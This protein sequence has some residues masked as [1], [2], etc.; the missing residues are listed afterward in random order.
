[1]YL[2]DH[3]VFGVDLNPVAVELAEV[4]LWLNALSDDRFV[5]WFGLQ[6]HCGNSLIGARR[7]TFPSSSLTVASSSDSHSWLNRAPEKLPMNEL[8]PKGQI[9]HF[10]LPDSGMAHYADKVFKERYKTEITAINRWRKEITKKFDR[11]EIDR[12]EKLSATIDELWQELASQLHK[13]RE[14]TTDPYL[15]LIHI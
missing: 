8:L 2:A 1:M 13:L 12:L 4:S 5:P 7:E 3:N 10:L 15:S 9:W 6:L 14:R 11:K